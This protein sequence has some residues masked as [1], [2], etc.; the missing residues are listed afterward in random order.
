M[1]LVSLDP[2]YKPATGLPCAAKGC[3]EPRVR[4]V[5]AYL[6]SKHASA[7]DVCSE[8]FALLHEEG[9]LEVYVSCP[10]G[11]VVKAGSRFCPA[12]DEEVKQAG[13]K[14]G[15]KGRIAAEVLHLIGVEPR[16][17]KVYPSGP[18]KKIALPPAQRPLTRAVPL[19]SRTT[20]APPPGPVPDVKR[21][22]A[23]E[24][25]PPDLLLPDG[26]EELVRLREDLTQ[27]RGDLRTVSNWVQG[28]CDEEPTTLVT[29]EGQDLLTRIRARLSIAPTVVDV[30]EVEPPRFVP[31]PISGAPAISVVVPSEGE[32]V[33]YIAATR[34]QLSSA[35]STLDSVLNRL[36]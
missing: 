33:V 4:V 9:E 23:D 13:F 25:V 22:P 29:A 32:P 14:V 7:I 5:R 30:A 35:R 2:S 28:G 18:V 21:E 10:C 27:L 24:P 12:H 20:T 17:V 15:L 8:H 1:S 26:R 11:K 34:K 6:G 19:P 16:P 31:T 36:L 3:H